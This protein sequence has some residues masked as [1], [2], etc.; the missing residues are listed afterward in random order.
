MG[1]GDP[2]GLHEA[3]PA[4]QVRVGDILTAAERQAVEELALTWGDTYDIGGQGG[5][6]FAR[7]DDG[8]GEALEG[9]TQAELE[10]AIRA[11]Q[12]QR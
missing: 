3:G 9:G 12:A 1:P 11:D 5:R 2:R 7:R 6:Y 8:T 10:A 4:G